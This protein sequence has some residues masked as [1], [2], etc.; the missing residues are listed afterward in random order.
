VPKVA[1]SRSVRVV[2]V[3]ILT[4]VTVSAAGVA[5]TWLTLGSAPVVAPNSALVMRV[6]ADLVE[7]EPSRLL[8]PFLFPSSPTLRSVTAALRRAKSDPRVSSL[9]IVP[10]GTAGLWAR[11]QE[12]RDAVLDFRTSK[13]PVTAFLEFGSDQEYFL[14][15]AADRIVMVPTSTL[16]LTGLASYEI[17]LRGTLEKAGAVADFVHVGD[18]KSAPNT[19]TERGFTP[20]HREMAESLNRDLFDQLVSGIATARRKTPEEVRALI[21]EGP[22]LPEDALR[23]GLIDGLAYEDQLLGHAEGRP[24]GARRRPRIELSAYAARNAPGFGFGRAHPIALIY[25]VGT[26][27]SGRS[28]R[29]AQGDVVGSQTLIDAIRK[30]REDAGVKAVVLRIDSPGGSSIASDVVWREL[31]LTREQKPLIVSMSDLAASGG[32]Y[33]AMP[34]HVIV[35]QPGTLT[36]SIGIFGGKFVT[37][38][39][40]EKL[41][42]NIEAVSQG[43]FAEMNSPGRPWTPE[44]RAKLQAQLEA[45]YDQWVEKAAEVRKTTPEKIDA[46]AQGRVWTGRQ[47][48]AAGLVD[49]LGGLDR[50]LSIARQRAKLP[51]GDDSDITVY[52]S[53]RGWFE[54]MSDP[55]GSSGGSL[56]AAAAWELLSPEERRAAAAVLAPIRTFRPG[57]PLALMPFVFRR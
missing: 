1:L 19:F 34:A 27:A 43:R 17:F 56:R 2:L 51:P 45:F 24:E 26:I 13:K 9:V 57:E 15:T 52:P 5:F 42:A 29:S 38:G 47:A 36:G 41:G 4:A 44:E 23:A 37:G 10:G 50:A 48:K 8:G 14:A 31:M 7:V 16:D 39:T 22:F 18:Y 25:A 49:E 21:D 33:I 20:A 30:A 35:A 53:R 46:V 32:Y 55:L 54:M 6:D 11:T 28:G 40:L 12:L 3:L